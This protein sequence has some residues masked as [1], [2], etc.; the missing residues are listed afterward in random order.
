MQMPPEHWESLEQGSPVVVESGGPESIGAPPSGVTGNDSEQAAMP[1]M[2]KG[3]T[4]LRSVR[5]RA[6][7]MV[8]VQ[9]AMTRPAAWAVALAPAAEERVSAG[10]RVE[11]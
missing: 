4:T 6:W 8:D 7:L 5:R 1:P 10:G 2:S 9:S 3:A 11:R